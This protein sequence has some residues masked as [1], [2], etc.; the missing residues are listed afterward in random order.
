M[1]PILLNLS[2][3]LFLSW[4]CIG[5][6]ESMASD[7]I[8][9]FSP[10]GRSVDTTLLSQPEEI[11]ELVISS[12]G[13]SLPVK[14]LGEGANLVFADVYFDERRRFID[15]RLKIIFLHTA[16]LLAEKPRWSLRIEGHCDPRGP[17]AYN[18]VRADFHLTDLMDYLHQLGI[19]SHQIS[20][21]NYG[22]DPVTCRVRSERCQEDNLRAEHIFPILSVG[23]TQR[24]CLVRLR[25]MGGGNW[26]GTR[27][28]SEHLPSLQRIQVASPSSS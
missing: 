26:P 23:Y 17:S 10:H 24:G 6:L 3:G 7:S 28:V 2:V 16:R 9:F 1:A 15:A 25:L 22:Q 14:G 27:Q 20:T 11:Q 5:G 8:L 12:Q 4:Y 13:Q 21:V 18:F 19:P